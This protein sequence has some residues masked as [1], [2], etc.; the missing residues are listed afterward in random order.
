V[1]KGK[2][3][4]K[5][6]MLFLFFAVLLSLVLS[7]FSY[8]TAKETYTSFYTEKIHEIVGYAATLVDGDRIAAYLDTMQTDAYY[9]ELQRQFNALKKEHGLMYLY[10]FRPNDEDFT[11]IL[12]ATNAG[13]APSLIASLGERDE[14]APE[15][16]DRFFADLEAKR[17]SEY[18]IIIDDQYGYMTSAWAPVLNQDGD[19]VA[20]VE[21]DLS[22]HKVLNALHRYIKAIVVIITAGVILFILVLLFAVQRSVTAPLKK[23]TESA[24]NFAS[25]EKLSFQDHRIKTGD[26]LESL[27][28]A[29]GQMARDIEN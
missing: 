25:G 13:D 20:V 17:P 22:M 16:R 10:I 11:Y 14:Y 3:Q 8:L 4:F 19:V 15:Y 12:E 23:L 29:F 28:D 7:T 9:D 27:A 6:T 26:E 18:P 1:K 21:A 5:L 2:L 24:L